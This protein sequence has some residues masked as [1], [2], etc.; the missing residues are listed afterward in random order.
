MIAMSFTL[1]DNFSR[2][3]SLAAALLFLMSSVPAA[4]Q[5]PGIGQKP[6]LGWSSSSQQSL[7]SSFLTQANIAAQSDAL[8]SSGL[9]IHGF[10]YINID[11]GWQGSFD[12]N[13][14]PLPDT[15]R[16][17]DIQALIR[18]I[19]SNGQQVGITWSPGVPQA[20][21]SSNAQI[22]DT[23]YHLKDILAVPY[24]IGNTLSPPSG[25]TSSS[26]TPVGNQAQTSTSLVS[27]RC[28]STTNCV[29]SVATS[30]LPDYKIDYTRS[31]AQ[32]YVSSILSLFAAWG[33]DAVVLDG[34]GPSTLNQSV[35]NQADVAAWG[36]AITQNGRPIWFTVSSALDQDYLPTWERYANARRIAGNLE[37]AGSCP[38]ITNWPLSSQKLYD[39]VSWQNTAG[40]LTGW[41][42]LGPL[43]IGDSATGGLSPAEQES[44][45]TFWAMANAPMYLGGDL[46]ALDQVSR[47]RLTN[48]EVLAVDQ[49][50]R[51]AA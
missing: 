43:V 40:P 22:L 18:H 12:S 13:G 19:H 41:N 7:S 33:V 10:T 25:T 32:E 45:I 4:T 39:L 31:G 28:V 29:A 49:S 26:N 2:P 42:D 20:A 17:P 3:W 1:K 48:D 51:P 14:R 6:Y 50:G 8:Q 5:T 44:L 15:S 24:A 34:V 27:S 47:Q 30:S 35:D 11:S 37:C 9:G 16:F 36:T 46:I 38:T 21:V 23:T